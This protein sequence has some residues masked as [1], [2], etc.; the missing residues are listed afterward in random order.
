[1]KQPV[2]NIFGGPG[3]G[4]STT[5]AGVFA[6]LKLHGINCELVTEFAKDLTWE[7]NQEVLKDQVYILGEQYHRMHRLKN[8]V[9]LIITDCP[10]LLSSVYGRLNE[11]VD[12]E[13]H[14]F[15]FA[16]NQEFYNIMF[17]LKRVKDYNESGRNQTFEEAK[18]LDL[19]I[20]DTIK[21]GGWHPH[22]VEGNYKGINSIAEQMLNF[23]DVKSHTMFNKIE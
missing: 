8:K 11:I 9:D 17:N 4:K 7:N 2:L 21:Q 18:E 14:K 13:Y 3:A 6:L 23:F 12:E 22:I 10:L 20:T 19:I 15:V 1:M 5:C 16:L